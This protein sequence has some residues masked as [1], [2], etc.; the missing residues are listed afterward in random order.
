MKKDSNVREEPEKG[1]SPRERPKHSNLSLR[2]TNETKAEI[3][4]LRHVYRH[5][6]ELRFLRPSR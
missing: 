3:F 6:V 4:Q 2:R 1:K 5:R